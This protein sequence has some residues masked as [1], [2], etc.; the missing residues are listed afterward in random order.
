MKGAKRGVLCG[1]LAGFLTVI[2]LYALGWIDNRTQGDP[3]SWCRAYFGWLPSWG[4]KRSDGFAPLTPF[5]LDPLFWGFTAS[6]VLTVVV[7]KL[8]RPDPERV[9]KY[10][11]E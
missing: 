3:A 8:G 4:D 6:L 10:F 2:G 5:G 11:P 9:R 1:M 7:S